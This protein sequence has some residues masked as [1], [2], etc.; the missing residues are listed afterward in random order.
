MRVILSASILTLA[1]AACSA[2]PTPAEVNDQEVTDLNTVNSDG[3][4]YA[5]GKALPAGDLTEVTLGGKV[6]GPNGFEVTD[7]MANDA[8]N[9]ADMRAYVAC[10]KGTVVCDPARQPAGTVYTYVFVVYPG[11]DNGGPKGPGHDFSD[12]ESATAFRMTQPAYG[13]TGNA[14]YAKPEALAAIGAKADIVITCDAGKIIWTV[15]SGDGGNQWGQKEPL[16]FYWQSA[17]PPAGPAKAYAFDADG[18]TAMGSG[19]YPAAKD[20]VKN[21][22]A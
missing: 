3:E 22:C 7:T 19:P 8:G 13:F 21:A 10:P 9:F 11:G 14:G 16:T 18:T 1:L 20:G 12:I 5:K 4:A 15:S 2:D 17:L 6:K